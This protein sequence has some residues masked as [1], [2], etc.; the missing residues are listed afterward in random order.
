MSAS[1]IDI[2]SIPTDPKLARI[3]RSVM[4]GHRKSETIHEF[5]CKLVQLVHF[6]DA[7]GRGIGY[8]YTYI[9]DA[10][11]RRFPTVKIGGPHRGKPT[12]MSY[13]ELQKV[14]GEFNRQGVKLPF[15]P[16][17]KA[18]TKKSKA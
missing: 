9:R 2:S 10:I 7:E 8:D 4:F 11:L 3:W 6:H 5:A 12:K 16:R 13:K 17:R 1:K 15:R 18:K 14:T